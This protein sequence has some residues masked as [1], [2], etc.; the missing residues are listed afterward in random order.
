[1]CSDNVIKLKCS[2]IVQALLT[3][4]EKLTIFDKVA[5]MYFKRMEDFNE[6]TPEAR[7]EALQNAARNM[8]NEELS[9]AANPMGSEVDIEK[10][11]GLS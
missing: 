5:E 7:N 1:M 9:H 10:D 3:E 6:M 11:L 4:E 2:S 8:A